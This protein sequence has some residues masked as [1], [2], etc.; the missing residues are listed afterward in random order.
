MYSDCV[1]PAARVGPLGTWHL[2]PANGG[3]Q[4]HLP[5]ERKLRLLS[6]KWHFGVAFRRRKGEDAG[7][8]T[9]SCGWSDLRVEPSLGSP[10]N[11]LHRYITLCPSCTLWFC[12][13]AHP[14]TLYTPSSS[15]GVL[16]WPTF[17]LQSQILLRPPTLELPP[18][19]L[20][21]T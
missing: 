15:V 9:I 19:P 13:F 5:G 14:P 16:L 2:A 18:T 17:H 21:S 1:G 12:Y 8:A 11:S 6:E 4:R 10:D 20:A 3:Y 7:L